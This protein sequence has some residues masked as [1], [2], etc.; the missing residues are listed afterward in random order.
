VKNVLVVCMVDSIHINRWL[1]QF[2]GSEIRFTIL[3]SRKFRRIHSGLQKMI[4]SNPKNFEIANYFFPFFK[5]LGYVD[6]LVHDIL[7]RVVPYFNRSNELI[8]KVRKNEFD[9]S[10]LIEIQHAGYLY[11]EAFLHA[12]QESKV[13]LTNWG[14]DIFYFSQFESDKAKIS[15]LLEIVDAYS[16]ECGRDYELARSLGFNGLEL[17]V[18]PNGGGFKSDIL[19]RDL[20]QITDRKRIYVKGYGGEFGLAHFSAAAVEKYLQNDLSYIFT[21][22]SVTNDVFPMLNRVQSKFPLNVEIFRI[23]ES[24]SH[25]VAID[26]LSESVVCIGASKS[27]GISTTFLE[28]LAV[29]CYPIQTNTSCANEWLSQGFMA[30][31]VEPTTNAILEELCRVLSDKDVLFHASQNNV[32][33]AREKLAYTRIS[34]VAK[35]F[36]AF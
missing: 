17:P 7:G 3:A 31:I 9:Y 1:A 10:H 28:A 18:I 5:N 32:K 15:Q 8:R 6:F 34:S 33:L 36:Y 27:D 4:I 30:S 11:L 25:A 29:G 20:E 16:A 21:F 22:V 19:F 24:L 23:S 14:S 13:I 26:L 35:E 12:S 2:V